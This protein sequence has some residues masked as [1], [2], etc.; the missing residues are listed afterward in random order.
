MAYCKEEELKSVDLNSPLLGYNDYIIYDAFETY[1]LTLGT[2]TCSW[3]SFSSLYPI[4]L[5]YSPSPPS[6]YWA[7]VFDVIMIILFMM[8]LKHIN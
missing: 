7:Y 3:Y 6:E 5:A 2:I 1:K 4:D 8:L